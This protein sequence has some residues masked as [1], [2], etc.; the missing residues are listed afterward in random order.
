MPFPGNTAGGATVGGSLA[1]DVTNGLPDFS[2]VVPNECNDGHDCGLGT[3]DN[4]LK[5]WLPTIMAG[6]DY[7]AG[8]LAIVVTTDEDDR[9]SGNVVLTAVI[10]PYTHGVVSSTAFTHYSLTRLVDDVLGLPDLR[11]SA[12][13]NGM[14]GPFHL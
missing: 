3:A 4:W 2:F 9:Q 14:R 13:A 7:K 11:N 10:S 6:K 12:S 1:N 5:S 8:K